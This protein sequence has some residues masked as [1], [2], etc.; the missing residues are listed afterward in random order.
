MSRTRAAGRTRPPRSTTAPGRVIDLDRMRIEHAIR[1]R[2]RYRWVRPR[3]EREGGGWKIVSP[4]CSRQVDA[5]G[6]EIDIAWLLSAGDG[7][8]LLHARDHAARCWRL[9]AVC[10]NLADALRCLCLDPQRIFWP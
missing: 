2:R 5:G 8:W 7:R 1:D 4:N 9:E 10:T 3:V 6:G